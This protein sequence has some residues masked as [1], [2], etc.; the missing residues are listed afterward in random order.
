MPHTPS[1]PQYPLLIPDEKDQLNQADRM[2][3]EI[4][5]RA[6]IQDEQNI[7]ATNAFTAHGHAR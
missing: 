6:D 3:T 4:D 5:K 7:S 1:T 2:N